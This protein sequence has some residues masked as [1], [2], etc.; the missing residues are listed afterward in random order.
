MLRQRKAEGVSFIQLAIE[1]S[2]IYT[3]YC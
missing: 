3:Y 1:A 2:L